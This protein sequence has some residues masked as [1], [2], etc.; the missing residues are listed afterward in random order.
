M[1]YNRIMDFSEKQIRFAAARVS[2]LKQ[3]AGTG[4]IGTMGEKTVH[5]VLKY[6][7]QP[8]GD[9]HEVKIGRYIADIYDG[10][11]VTEIQT[12]GFYRLKGKLAAFLKLCPVRVVYPV[13][14]SKRMIW[15]DPATGETTK[16]RVCPA[17]RGEYSVFPEL[18]AIKDLLGAA[19]LTITLCPVDYDEYRIKDGFGKDGKRGS[20][21]SDRIPAAIGEETDLD[22]L[23]SY[24]RFVPAALC[25]PF[26]S[27]DFAAAAKIRQPLSTV[28]INV[29][30]AVGA[31]SPC[32]KSGRFILYKRKT[33]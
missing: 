29:L 8:D 21:L 24:N 3:N 26:T 16:P 31:I 12:R 9:L 32:G 27:R 33:F 13:R 25:E 5:S 22:S 11:T 7:Y 30:C 2:A 17:A 6:Y 19:G 4:G 20:T 28:A 18:Y 10:T 14:R 1:P 15:I 23:K